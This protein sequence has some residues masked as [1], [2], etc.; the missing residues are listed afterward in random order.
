MRR[1]AA[2]V[3]CGLLLLSG[4]S[5]KTP[6]ATPSGQTVLTP[7]SGPSSAPSPTP[8]PYPSDY[9]RAVLAAWANH[10][11]ARLALLASDVAPFNAI[12]GSPD[13][14]WT[15]MEC[16]GAAGTTGCVYYNNDGDQIVIGVNNEK[17]GNHEYH[18]GRLIVWDPMKFPTTAKSYVDAFMRAWIGGNVAREKLLATD[19]VVAHYAALARIDLNYTVDDTGGG[20]AG[21]TYVHITH[22]GGF[23]QRV[24]VNN[25]LMGSGKP[26]AIANCFP[27]C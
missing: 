25:E 3:M 20:A 17:Y 6:S 8:E 21:S 7:S 27:I 9:H 22:S 14:H 4:C 23:D 1:L 10:D 26:D 19:N 18:A 2:V 12:P 16:S 24:R 11:S 13:P 5:K 15:K